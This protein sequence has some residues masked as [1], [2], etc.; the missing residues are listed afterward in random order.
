VSE[1]DL[2]A[3]RSSLQIF[4]MMYQ[5]MQCRYRVLVRKSSHRKAKLSHRVER[6][7][8]HHKKE[9]TVKIEDERTKRET[10]DSFIGL[11]C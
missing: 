7:G 4:D 1:Q 2:C 6:S 10:L 5:I 11:G 9:C 3:I 8:L